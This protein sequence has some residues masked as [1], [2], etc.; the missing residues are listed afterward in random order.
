MAIFASFFLRE[1]TE[2]SGE[3]QGSPDK[4]GIGG[5]IC[6][7]LGLVQPN[8]NTNINKNFKAVFAIISPFNKYPN[9]IQTNKDEKDTI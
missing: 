1:K 9:I 5:S 4:F 2:L 8:N 3:V 6:G 7:G